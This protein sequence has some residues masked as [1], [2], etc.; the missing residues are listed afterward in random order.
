MI[1]KKRANTFAPML[2]KNYK[3][4]FVILKKVTAFRRVFQKYKNQ[5]GLRKGLQLLIPYSINLRS[6]LDKLK[7]KRNR[8]NV[9][10]YVIYSTLNWTTIDSIP[11][12]GRDES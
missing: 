5:V 11:R 9:L 12:R 10:T 2:Y 6:F 4:S 3:N 1:T 8:S 7:A